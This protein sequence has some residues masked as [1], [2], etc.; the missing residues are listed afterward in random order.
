L[1]RVPVELNRAP[2]C[3]IAGLDPA[4]HAALASARGYRNTLHRDRVSMDA[5]VER[6]HDE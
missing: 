2:S 4:I 6:A 3:V 1:E 5:R